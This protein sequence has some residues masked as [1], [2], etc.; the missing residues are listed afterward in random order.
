MQGLLFVYVA[1]ILVIFFIEAG[2][3]KILHIFHLVKSS[4]EE[5]YIR[6][7]V[8]SIKSNVI[9]EGIQKSK[10]FFKMNQRKIITAEQGIKDAI[11]INKYNQA[12]VGGPYR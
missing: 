6:T 5:N 3:E 1:P 7:S 11:S 2:Y 4:T 12:Y 8:P 10:R 9:D